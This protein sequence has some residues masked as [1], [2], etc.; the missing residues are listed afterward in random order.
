MTTGKL[1]ATNPLTVRQFL[2]EGKTEFQVEEAKTSNLGETLQELRFG[3]NVARY[4]CERVTRNQRVSE[5]SHGVA[6]ILAFLTTPSAELLK[7]ALF[8]DL[9]EKLVGDMPAPIKWKHPEIS[10]FLN[11]EGERMDAMLGI[12]VVLSDEEQRLLKLA[13]YLEASFFC[14]EERTMGNRYVDVIFSNL[15]N[16]FEKD[17]KIEEFP[18]ALELWNWLKERYASLSR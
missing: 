6:V 3:G 11:E 2:A 8:H 9:N 10:K 15:G 14:L 4:H 12:T 7:A 18:K 5:H 17:R 13:D 16:F 1:G